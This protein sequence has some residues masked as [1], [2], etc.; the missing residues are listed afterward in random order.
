MITTSEVAVS[1]TIDDASQLNA[2]TEELILYGTVN[3]EQNQTIICVVGDM[4]TENKGLAGQIF[5]A[6]MN[7]PIRMISYGG[8]QN[9]ISL[10][11]D[12][13]YKDDSLKTLHQHLFLKKEQQ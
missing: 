7:I 8:S 12:Q 13:Q 9:N 4:M 6:L 11:V 10:V 2:I 5:N 1:L 3:V